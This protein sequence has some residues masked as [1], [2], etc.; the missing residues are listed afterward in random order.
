MAVERPGQCT[1]LGEMLPKY[2][3]YCV[4]RCML[5]GLDYYWH[6]KLY[7]AENRRLHHA[8]CWTLFCF[9][10]LIKIAHFPA[11]VPLCYDTV[12]NTITSYICYPKLPFSPIYS[13]RGPFQ[14][15]SLGLYGPLAFGSSSAAVLKVSSCGLSIVGV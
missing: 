11:T 15:T 2:I 7:F 8:S 14:S 3:L 10:C 6:C 5:L 13:T 4:C 1:R 9:K 12:P